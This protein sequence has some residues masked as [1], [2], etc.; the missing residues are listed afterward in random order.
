VPVEPGTICI[1]VVLQPATTQFF[2]LPSTLLEKPMPD[3]QF[4]TVLLMILASASLAPIPHVQFATTLLEKINVRLT[5]ELLPPSTALRAARLLPLTKL[6]EKLTLPAPL[7]DTKLLTVTPSATDTRNPSTVVI[8]LPAFT[9][10]VSV[11]ALP[12]MVTPTSPSKE[13]GKL[14][15][16]GKASPLP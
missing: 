13:T 12:S 11:V 7:N 6:R 16:S 5:D 2:I 14:M 9:V 10:R 4:Q 15:H 3:S 1:A 8:P